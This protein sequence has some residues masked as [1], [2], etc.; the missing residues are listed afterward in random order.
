[1]SEEMNNGGGEC[2]R[3]SGGGKQGR[4]DNENCVFE[5]EYLKFQ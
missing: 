5:Y 3:G 2:T 1:M 4:S